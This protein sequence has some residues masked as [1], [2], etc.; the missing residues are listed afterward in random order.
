MDV[1]VIIPTYNRAHILAKTLEA[2]AR[3][4]GVVG[5]YEVLVVDDGSKD[6]TREI[7]WKQ[8]ERVPIPLHYYYQPNKK[9]GAAR[10][11][12][13]K[14]ARGHLLIL[15]GDD[16]VPASQLVREHQKAHQ[17]G[18]EKSVAVGYTRWPDDFQI[19]RF[20]EYIGEEGWQFGYRLI[21]DPEDLPFN[22]F[23]TSNLSIGRRF[24]LESRGFDESFREYGWEDIEL[25][26]RLKQAGMRLKFHRDA[27]GYHY[28][29]MSMKS[30]VQRQ[31]K[32]GYSA[33]HFSQLHPEAASFLSL[34]T[35]LPRYGR[36]ERTKI[37]A[38]TWLCHLTERLNWV[39]VSRYY[40]HLM[41]Y[42]YL[43]GLRTA[44]KEKEGKS[45]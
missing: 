9:Q 41:T 45:R 21:Q 39:D 33:W 30:F 38:L 7:V 37:K 12:G 34:D 11:L 6:D 19:T 2:L 23:Y 10:N 14:G 4:E 3:Q 24:F 43:E 5:G 31:K 1:S 28:H 25:S 36:L 13:A 27:V 44:I 15:L 29:P 17:N 35:P 18:D 26:L 16:V 22:F 32:V 40:P 8:Q 20:M 42:Y